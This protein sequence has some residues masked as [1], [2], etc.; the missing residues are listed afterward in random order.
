MAEVL[1]SIPSIEGKKKKKS[2]GIIWGEKYKIEQ[3]RKKLNSREKI[4][5]YKIQK[6]LPWEGKSGSGFQPV[7]C[8]QRPLDGSG[9]L[10]QET[11]P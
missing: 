1:G 4:Q 2:A 11:A 5:K 8:S 9:V 7:L 3:K 6:L 10:F